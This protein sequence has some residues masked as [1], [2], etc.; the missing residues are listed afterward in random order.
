VVLVLSFSSVS[1]TSLSA[2][3]PPVVSTVE[4]TAASEVASKPVTCALIADKALAFNQSPTFALLEADL[5]RHPRLALVERTQIARIIEEET[6]QRALGAEGGDARRRLGG[7]LKAQMVVILRA[8]EKKLGD[9]QQ[10]QQ[11]QTVRSLHVM[12][13]GT[14]NGLRILTTDHVW[15]DK[16][17]HRPSRASARTLTA[18]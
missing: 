18:R 13:A 16:Q 5:T 2:G 7:L 15:D 6:L 17:P 12:I 8:A 3:V 11:Q 14:G 10:P 1:S 9:P 4:S